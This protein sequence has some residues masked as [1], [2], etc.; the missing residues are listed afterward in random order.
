MEAYGGASEIGGATDDRTFRRTTGG[1]C[2]DEERATDKE[3]PAA[4][5]D[6]R[7]HRRILLGAH[8]QSLPT[9]GNLPGP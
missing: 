8:E 5:H 7:S 1:G 6:N 3:A 2:V 9:G 4:E